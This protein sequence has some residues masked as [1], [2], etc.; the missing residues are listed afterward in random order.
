VALT[1]Q[2]TGLAQSAGPPDPHPSTVAHLI[3][4]QT[5]VDYVGLADQTTNNVY[6]RP[7]DP[8]VMVWG[9]PG[10]PSTWMVRAQ[11]NSFLT[12]ILKRAYPGWATDAFFTQYFGERTPR[13]RRYQQV[14]ATGEAPHFRIVTR[15][16]DLLPG[17]LIA[18]NY[19]AD[20]GSG[21]GHLV[22]VR[23][24]KGVYTGTMTFAGETQYP[25]EVVDCTSDPHGM[26]GR[27]DY[28][29]F[30]DTRL[31]AATVEY[32]GGGYGH[33]MFYAD[34]ATGVF[35]RYRWSVNTGPA[36]THTTAGRPITAVRVVP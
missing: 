27:G 4:A 28:V 19:V 11:C 14:W 12:S 20:T 2:L 16:A 36:R 18:I 34:D 29:A 25:V 9:A 26:Y 17:D 32:D 13:A 35:S 33:M 21:T 6:K 22:I 24:R 31:P 23:R 7:G 10:D 30:P 8:T 15:V 3:E 1:G 5:L